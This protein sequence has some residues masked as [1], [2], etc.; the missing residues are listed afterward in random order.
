MV[1]PYNLV[2]LGSNKC[3]CLCCVSLFCVIYQNLFCSWHSCIPRPFF[4]LCVRVG[5]DLV[6]IRDGFCALLARQPPLSLCTSCSTRDGEDGKYAISLTRQCHAPSFRIARPVRRYAVTTC[7]VSRPRK[8]HSHDKCPWQ[9]I[10]KQTGTRNFTPNF[11]H[12]TQTQ[13]LY[14]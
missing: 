5:I 7:N 3:V 6:L 8:Q 11:F 12:Q 10:T 9:I 14:Y 1:L 4:L 13:A 2:A